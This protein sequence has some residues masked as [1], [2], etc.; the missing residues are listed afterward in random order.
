M[1]RESQM[2]SEGPCKEDFQYEVDSDEEQI[3]ETNLKTGKV[4]Y[5]DIPDDS[6]SPQNFIEDT[7]PEKMSPHEFVK[8]II[9]GRICRI[10]RE[11]DKKK[12]D[13]VCSK[14]QIEAE[15]PALYNDLEILQIQLKNLAE[16]PVRLTMEEEIRKLKEL[17]PKL[18]ALKEEFKAELKAFKEE[19]KALKEKNE[20]LEQEIKSLKT[21][22]PK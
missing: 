5:Y 12:R 3:I 17:E 7:T 10:K 15:L 14:K 16:I 18:N 9:R 1:I 19:L 21:T 13:L 20:S 11:I 4:L 6:P 2:A 22:M 8:D